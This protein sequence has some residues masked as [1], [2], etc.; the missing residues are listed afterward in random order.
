MLVVDRLLGRQQVPPEH[1]EPVMLSGGFLEQVVGESN[2]QDALE[3]ASA[4]R[5][6][7]G[8]G[9]E[10]VATLRAEPTNPDD[11]NAIRVE[12]DG[13]LIGYLNRG[14]AHSFRPTADRLAAAG[15]V[16]TCQARIVDAWER[17]DSDRGRLRV[18]LDL[19]LN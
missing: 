17:E 8:V 4:G 7:D 2:Y 13:R 1:L 3:A 16:G 19:G 18:I 6:T 10:C 14:A 9:Y 11:P 12:L 5:P 15:Q